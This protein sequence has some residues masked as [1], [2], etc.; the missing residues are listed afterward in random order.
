MFTPLSAHSTH[1]YQTCIYCKV[2]LQQMLSPPLGPFMTQAV[3][4]PI[5]ER[6][7]R[8]YYLHMD[9]FEAEMFNVDGQIYGT[10]IKI[11]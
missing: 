4:L 2:K 3:F 9:S 10:L 7:E 1:F 5:S 8:V 6:A 11:S